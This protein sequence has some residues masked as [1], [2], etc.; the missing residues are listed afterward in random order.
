ME[1]DGPLFGTPVNHGFL[2]VGKDPIAVDVICARLMGFPLEKITYLSLAA[3]A[4]IGQATHIET[5][6]TPPERLERQYRVLTSG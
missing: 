5:R 2:A 3:W 6:G 1:G 4:G